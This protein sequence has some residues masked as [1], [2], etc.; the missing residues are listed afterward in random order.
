MRRFLYG[1]VLAVLPISCQAQPFEKILH[2]AAKHKELILADAVIVAAWSAD[3]ASTVN[4]ERNCPSCVE[5]NPFLGPHPSR[6]AIWISAVGYAGVQTTFN[7]LIWHY[8][9]DPV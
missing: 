4:D 9:P 2:Y 1:C 5:T 7:H 8:A 3:A 6:H